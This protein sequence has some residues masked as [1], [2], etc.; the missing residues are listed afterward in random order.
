[1]A[2]EPGDT[3]EPS[4]GGSAG[5][6]GGVQGGYRSLQNPEVG[7]KPP[8]CGNTFGDLLPDGNGVPKKSPL[9]PAV[10]ILWALTLKAFL[11]K[12]ENQHRYQVPE[13]PQSPTEGLTSATVVNQDHRDNTQDVPPFPKSSSSPAQTD[14]PAEAAVTSQ[15]IKTVSSHDHK[16]ALPSSSSSSAASNSRVEQTSVCGPEPAA[17]LQRCPM[18][19]LLF[20]SGFSQMDLDTHLALCLSEV[21]TDMTW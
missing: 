11:T 4:L 15:N 1:M 16:P 17:V 13:L 18:C 3:G 9:E 6:D 7:T 14:P 5:W 8:D 20:P 21:R 10:E 12:P 2:G 19:C